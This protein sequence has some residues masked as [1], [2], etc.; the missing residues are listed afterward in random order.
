[1]LCDLAKHMKARIIKEKKPPQPM[2]CSILVNICSKE[3]QL[4]KTVFNTSAYDDN[5][6][7]YVEITQPAGKS[8]DGYR[9]VND[10]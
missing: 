10:K 2:L 3:R 6:A 7:I 1:M 5:F 4:I 8:A 9:T